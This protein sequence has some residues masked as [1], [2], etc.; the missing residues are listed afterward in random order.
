MK[1]NKA[2]KA[3]SLAIHPTLSSVYIGCAG[4]GLNSQVAERFPADGTH[5]ERYAQVFPSVEINSTFY[6]PHLAK[7]Y[8]RWA[9]S[10]PDAFRFCVKVPRIIS[11]ESKLRVKDDVIRAFIDQIAPL[12]DKLGC[13]LLQ[14]PPS[15]ALI[16]A[17]AQIFF[18]TLRRLTNADVACEPRHASWFTPAAANLMKN[19][20]IACVHADPSPVAGVKPIG[21]SHTLYLRLHGAPRIYYS[22]YDQAFIDKVAAQIIAARRGKR[23]VWCI[24]D[25]T[26]SG[27][28]VPNALS[29]MERIEKMSAN[30]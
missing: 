29:L 18:A 17:E 9:A 12:G 5:L 16:Q 11:H 20:E 4:W 8:A 28:A 6:R 24:F 2:S 27:E 14:L 30:L 15:L 22:A 19:A 26:A 25:N 23:R 1:E 13:L 21:D 3:S 10:V 7:T